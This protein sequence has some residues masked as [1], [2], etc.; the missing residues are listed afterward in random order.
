M[1][2]RP[3]RRTYDLAE[4]RRTVIP[5]W[6]VALVGVIAAVGLLLA[7]ATVRGVQPSATPPAPPP[8]MPA[9]VAAKKPPATA[10]PAAADADEGQGV[11]EESRQAA[12]SFVR[13]WLDRNPATRRAG[14][15]QSSAPALAEQLMLTDPAN[16]PAATPV[17]AP[18]A[19]DS[20]A[21]ATQFS[22]RLSTG[23]SIRVYLVAD[24]ESRFGW[25]ATSVEQ[26]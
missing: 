10:P 20:S 7:V 3:D 14:L 17:G 18:V 15:Q 26:A 12:S 13:A 8:S 23:R 22:Q 2:S 1:R 16:V 9:P 24:P 6:Q 21:Y 11:P 5:V 19:E 25:L 4:P